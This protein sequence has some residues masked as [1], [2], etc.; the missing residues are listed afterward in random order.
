MI[1][2]VALLLLACVF[3]GSQVALP[4]I[5]IVVGATRLLFFVQVFQLF[6]FFSVF[7]S[8]LRLSVKM[9]SFSTFRNYENSLYSCFYY[10]IGLQKYP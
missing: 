9:S 4:A 5:V 8:V 6:I 10:F 1:V 2:T 7:S 3:L